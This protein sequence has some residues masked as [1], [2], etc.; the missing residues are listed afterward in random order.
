MKLDIDPISRNARWVRLFV[1]EK[2]LPLLRVEVDRLA[3]ENR[4]AQ[5]LEKNPLGQVPGSAPDIAQVYSSASRKSKFSEIL[6]YAI[7][8]AHEMLGRSPVLRTIAP[9]SSS[10]DPPSKAATTHLMAYALRVGE[11]R[12]DPAR[13]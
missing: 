13:V 7:V 6:C 10:S 4:T 5:F 11:T 3:G 1:A 8:V 9:V 2:Y 12:E